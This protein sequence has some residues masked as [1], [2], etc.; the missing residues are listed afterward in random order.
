MWSS[1][2]ER[3]IELDAP[4]SSTGAP[5]PCIFASDGEVVF[6]YWLASPASE[7]GAAVDRSALVTVKLCRVIKYGSPNDEALRGHRLYASGLRSY[8]A[9]EVL[10]SSWIAELE[11]ANRVHPRHSRA[12]FADL[13]HYIFTFHD[14]TLEFVC[15]GL[16]WS[17]HSG[18]PE[19]VVRDEIMRR[20]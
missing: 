5:E 17:V 18:S 11:M 14:S 4:P 12:M 10:N 16:A 9:Y 8:S 15:C 20:S 13:R 19:A 2:T 3:L 1:R 6:A 7:A